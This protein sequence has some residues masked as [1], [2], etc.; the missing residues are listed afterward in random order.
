[1]KLVLVRLRCLLTGPRRRA[2][3]ATE[4]EH[5]HMA[6]D[7]GNAGGITIG[8]ALVTLVEPHRGVEVE[9]NRWYERDHFYAG[10]LMGGGWSAG[11][12]WVAPKPRRELRGP[13]DSPFLPDIS[14]G[15]Y[16]ATYWVLADM[17]AE[18]I[19]WGSAQVKW[20]H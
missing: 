19:A 14:A 11:K 17:A 2:T 3:G 1:M 9:Y 7:A 20:L 4:G 5:T 6:Q 10:C 18:A 15:S 8:S 13:S 12:R 16:L